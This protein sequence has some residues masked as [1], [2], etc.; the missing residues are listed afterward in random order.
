MADDVV[1]LSLFAK[2]TEQ[3]G[4][5]DDVY[6]I[7]V[8]PVQ[9]ELGKDD[10]RFT[11]NTVVEQFLEQGE[12]FRG[13]PEGP[14]TLLTLLKMAKDER[15]VIKTM[16]KLAA[17]VSTQAGIADATAV[18]PRPNM[19]LLS[20]F[21]QLFRT[22]AQPAADGVIDDT[23]IQFVRDYVRWIYAEKHH[24]EPEFAI[25][26]DQPALKAKG[27]F[28]ELIQKKSPFLG[29][30]EYSVRPQG[31]FFIGTLAVDVAVSI[32]ADLVVYERCTF[33]SGELNQKARAEE[34]CYV[35]LFR[36]HPLLLQFSGRDEVISWY[37]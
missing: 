15:L 12:V 31:A 32:V 8:D 19:H 16:E 23:P 34:A 17:K 28:H 4:G 26:A 6:A 7:K 24:L 1:G 37:K 35:E 25:S 5:A 9:A 3:L 14:A 29:N 20:L 22:L 13:E 10:F 2:L 27:I 33:Y 30:P 11:A 18:T 36:K 21:Y